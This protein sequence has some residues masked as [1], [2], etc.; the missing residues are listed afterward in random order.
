MLCIYNICFA[1]IIYALQILY[2]LCKYYIC[3][4][5]Q[6]LYMLCKYYI[7]SANIIYALLCKYYICSADI[8]YALQIL[9]ML[10][11]YFICFGNSKTKCFA[12]I[13]FLFF[14]TLSS[15]SLFLFFFFSHFLPNFYFVQ[16]GI[17][18]FNH[19]KESLRLTIYRGRIWN[20]NIQIY[21]TPFNFYQLY[22][23]PFSQNHIS[24]LISSLL[25][26]STLLSS[27][28]F[29]FT[30]FS[31]LISS[32]LLKKNCYYPHLLIK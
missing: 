18:I 28:L 26:S 6:I 21:E 31:S 14:V 19:F 30:L 10:C 12:N 25:L 17:T 4:A 20:G 11:R 2:M 16:I 27:H 8:L 24:S 5:L 22:F 1:N 3:S 29:Y 32:H 23:I 7:C 13:F 15:P 9:Y